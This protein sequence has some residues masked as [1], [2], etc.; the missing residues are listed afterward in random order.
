MARGKSAQVK[1]VEKRIFAGKRKTAVAKVRVRHGT[2]KVYFNYLPAEE[3]QTFHRLAL[4]EPIEIYKAEMGSNPE[5]D[6]Y[7]FASGGGKESQ[8]EAARLAIARAIVELTGSQVLHR[9]YFEYDKHMVVPDSR[10]KE[11]RK[12]NDSKARAKR[13]KSYR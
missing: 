1:S 11:A 12:P 6:F 10:R 5:F 9:V 3:L 8:I 4:A 2:G 13:Q 7:V